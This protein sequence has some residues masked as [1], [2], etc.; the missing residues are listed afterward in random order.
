MLI[1][2]KIVE[3]DEWLFIEE[4]PDS[5]VPDKPLVEQRLDIDRPPVRMHN[6]QLSTSGLF[7]LHSRMYFDQPVHVHTEVEGEAITSQFIFYKTIDD[8]MPL[9]M[10]RHNIRY[11]PSLESVHEVKEGIEYNYFIAVI[12]KA[13]YL[14]LIKR[15]SLLHRD[16]VTAIEKGQYVSFSEDDLIATYEMQHTMSEL[17]ESKKTGEIRRLHTESRIVELLMYQ[18]EQY[19]D[20]SSQVST[21]LNDSDVGRLELARQILEQR[22]ANPPTQ[23]ELAS[24]VLTSESKLRKDFKEYFSVTIHDYLTRVRM[25]KARLYLLEDKLSVY[26][27]ALLTGYGHQN[28]FS[29]AFKKYYGISPGELKT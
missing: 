3:L 4:I 19:N 8:K 6:F 22:I 25:E 14:N 5:Y 11:I 13:Y 15:D 17:I 20:K 7:I 10:S 12:S 23:R 1:K 18:F 28:N 2:S 9:G 26:E 29:S 27:V 24:E 21:Q 16:F